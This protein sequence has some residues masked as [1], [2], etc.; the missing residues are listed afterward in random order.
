MDAE[1][2]AEQCSLSWAEAATAL[3]LPSASPCLLIT[4]GTNCTSS[5]STAAL[6]LLCA[7]KDAALSSSVPAFSRVD[8]EEEGME[9]GVAWG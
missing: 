7:G 3:V 4:A 5:A 8:L 2:G 6:W 9:W 1:A